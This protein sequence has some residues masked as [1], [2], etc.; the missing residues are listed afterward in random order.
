MRAQA[1]GMDIETPRLHAASESSVS[2]RFP[3]TLSTNAQALA[4]RRPVASANGR[5]AA[6]RS[7]AF[8]RAQRETLLELRAALEKNWSGAL[9]QVV[10][11]KPESSALSTHNGDAASDATDRDFAFSLLSQE[12]NALAE[13][14]DALAR[15]AEGRYGKCEVCGRP[16]P[17]ERLRAI[18][19]ARLTVECQARLEAGQ[20]LFVRAR[21][22]ASPF[23]LEGDEFESE[24][25][26][27]TT[28]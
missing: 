9:R 6:A 8:L 15:I 11:D 28:L 19:F 20:R 18:P 4:C 22:L 13:I 5:D 3:T 7:E 2:F 10:S 24:R 16:I 27:S 21:S 17:R 12:R 1:A 26:R 23:S 25:D 14:D